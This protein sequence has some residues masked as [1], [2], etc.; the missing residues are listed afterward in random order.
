MAGEYDGRYPD[1]TT[2]TPA[3][4][5]MAALAAMAATD[6]VPHH[7]RQDDDRR[8]DPDVEPVPA[9]ADGRP[10]LVRREGDVPS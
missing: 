10:A 3:T 2:A 5:A 9:V 8:R 7:E 1:G 6:K 4:P